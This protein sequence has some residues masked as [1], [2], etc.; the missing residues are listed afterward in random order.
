MSIYS[1]P[2]VTM[3]SFDMPWP[4]L[5]ITPLSD[6]YDTDRNVRL[7]VYTTYNVLNKSLY[8]MYMEFQCPSVQQYCSHMCAVH[9]T[10]M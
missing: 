6:F 2:R 4:H 8:I 10:E 5:C 9:F 7:H 3:W 1:T